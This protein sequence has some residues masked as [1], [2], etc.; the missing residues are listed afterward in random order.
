MTGKVPPLACHD[1]TSLQGSCLLNIRIGSEIQ[2]NP[3]WE[4][5]EIIPTMAEGPMSSLG[6]GSAVN[7]REH[8]CQCWAA[9]AAVEHELHVP[10]AKLDSRRIPWDLGMHASVLTRQAQV[11]LLIYTGRGSPC[12]VAVLMLVKYRER[13][14]ILMQHR[15]L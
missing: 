13:L 9:Q 11:M 7:P 12:S 1:Q 8:V 6:Q 5:P 15:H 4:Q 14:G 3:D 10:E 2:G